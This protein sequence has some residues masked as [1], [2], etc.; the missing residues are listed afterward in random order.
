M[1]HE[2]FVVLKT[3]GV[4]FRRVVV[5]AVLFAAP[6]GGALYF[7]HLTEPFKGPVQAEMT[8]ENVGQH[9]DAKPVTAVGPLGRPYLKVIR[10]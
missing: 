3:A 7:H 2:M 4:V 6:V 5:P 9:D 8:D 10:F 1:K